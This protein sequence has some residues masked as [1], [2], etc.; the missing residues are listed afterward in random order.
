MGKATYHVVPDAAGWAVKR[1]G[2]ATVR[3]FHTKEEAVGAAREES[4]DG[5]AD[6]VIHGRDGRILETTI[7]PKGFGS[8]RGEL[9]FKAGIDPTRPILEQVNRL[10]A[11]GRP[12]PDAA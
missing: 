12:K 7:R 11:S 2:G 8:H 9:K 1:E 5:K 10:E 4:R 6:I 3:T